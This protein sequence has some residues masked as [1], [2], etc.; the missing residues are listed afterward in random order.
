M[1]EHH[2]HDEG[3]IELFNRLSE[4]IDG[5]LDPPHRE[6]IERHLADCKACRICLS[7]LERTIALCRHSGRTPLPDGFSQRLAQMVARLPKE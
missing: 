7:T 5:E 2:D 1:T 3:C 6:L 4:F